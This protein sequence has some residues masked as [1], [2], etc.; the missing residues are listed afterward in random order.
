MRSTVIRG[1][2]R[3][4]E[5]N[6]YDLGM[7]AAR[8]FVVQGLAEYAAGVPRTLDPHEKPAPKARAKRKQ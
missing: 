8:E 2:Q 1:G 5:G 6:T 7:E 3:F 4:N